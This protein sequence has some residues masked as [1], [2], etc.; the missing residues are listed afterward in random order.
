MINFRVVL[1]VVGVLLIILGGFMFAT[2]AATS[3]H[4]TEDSFALIQSALICL[5]VGV[6]IWSTTRSSNKNIGKR[7]G[8]LIVAS[9][10]L[11]VALFSS[12]PYLLSGRIPEFSSAI[13][14]SASGLTTTGAT[15]FFDI[16]SLPPVI[17]L[18]RSLTQWIGGMGIIVLTIAIFPLLGIGGVELFVAEATGPT[19]DKIH[20]R[21]K[22][23]AK[24]LW[25]IYVGLTTLLTIILYFGGMTFFDAVNHALTTMATGGF[26]TKNDSMMHYSSA[27]IQYPIIFFMF[28]SGINYTVIYYSLIG[29]F[30][31]V[32]QSDEFKTYVFLVASLIFAVTVVVYQVTELPLEESF[33]SVAFQ[34]ISIITTTGFVSA[35][36]TAWT[37]ALTMLFFTLFSIGACGGSTSGG[38][39]IIRHLVFFKNSVLEFKR[40]LHPRGMIRIKI[41]KQIVSPR[42]LTHI[43]VFLL[44]YL[45]IF[46]ISSIVMSIVFSDFEQPFVTAI[47]SV[48]TSLGNV[49]PAIGELGPMD[50]FAKVPVFGKWFLVFLMFLGRLELFTILILF[51]PYFWKT[52]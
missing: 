22:E 29:N 20:P 50:N 2:V 47:G 21:I 3:L 23:T 24:R 10:W 30:K 17:L 11:F 36:Y 35:D 18:W 9:G 40:L 12:L 8:Y 16:E 52:N 4:G 49:G 48:A 25:M 45:I 33:R 41:D 7:E 43:L 34:I 27:A 13:F 19:S 51:T 1:N 28:L 26:S 42:I 46:I 39:K 32:W 15:V 44:L 5:L 31:K 37:P 38:I 6:L 14:E